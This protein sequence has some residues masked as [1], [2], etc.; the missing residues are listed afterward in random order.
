MAKKSVVERERNRRK[1]VKKYFL[2]WM[3]FKKEL[4]RSV[5]LED[6]LETHGKLQKI[7]RNRIPS[8]LCNR[9]QFSGRSRG[10]YRNFGLSRHFFRRLAQ[11]GF[12]PG[13]QKSSW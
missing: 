5:F 11:G 8:R 13:I 3:Y 4:K 1:L 7:P 6:R 2:S 9:C 12:L 10:Y